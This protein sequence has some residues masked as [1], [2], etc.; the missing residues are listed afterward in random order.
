M[1]PDVLFYDNDEHVTVIR[2][3]AR[4]MRLGA[5]LLLIG[6]QGVGKNK[7]T[8][9]FLH[10]IQRPRQYMQLHRYEVGK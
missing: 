1:I 10:L 9:R 3:M 4:D 8:D 6:N 2:N 7:I 5:H